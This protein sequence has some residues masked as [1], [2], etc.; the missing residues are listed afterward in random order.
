[1]V[2]GWLKMDSKGT[3]AE[4][5]VRETAGACRAAPCPMCGGALI[6]AR[7][8]FQCSRCHFSFCVGCEPG[9]TFTPGTAA[10]NV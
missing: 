7:E 3:P 10:D 8:Y 1:V 6:P 4:G 5:T 2:R 9:D